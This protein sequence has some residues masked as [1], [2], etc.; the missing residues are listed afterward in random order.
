MDKLLR[1]RV[2]YDPQDILKAAT[3]PADMTKYGGFNDIVSMKTIQQMSRTD[4]VYGPYDIVYTG[5]EAL[6][7]TYGCAIGMLP[8]QEQR[9]LARQERIC[10]CGYL[11]PKSY[12]LPEGATSK[13]YAVV[14]SMGGDIHPSCQD[15]VNSA[16]FIAYRDRAPTYPDSAVMTKELFHDDIANAAK[17]VLKELFP[18]DPM[19]RGGSSMSQTKYIAVQHNNNEMEMDHPREFAAILDKVSKNTGAVIVFFA[20]GTAPYHDSFD[21][22]H[23]ISSYMTEPNIVYEMENVWKVVGLIS[24]AEAVLATSLH[25]RIMSF[26]YFKP[27]ITWCSLSKHRQFISL[28]DTADSPQCIHTSVTWNV[29]VKYLGSDP[30]ITQDMTKHIYEEMVQKYLQGFDIWSTMLAQGDDPVQGKSA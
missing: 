9:E 18:D 15:A 14:N 25:V 5:G 1:T 20:A 2:G 12:L 3:T 4:S 10:D 21:V 23:E 6:G 16:D 17:E 22:Y 27:R 7:C 8:T 13:N 26:I 29:L 30:E 28:W 24:Q 19:I 11:V